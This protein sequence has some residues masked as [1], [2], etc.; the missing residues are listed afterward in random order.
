MEVVARDLADNCDR[1]GSIDRRKVAAVLVI[2]IVIVA[3]DRA[4]I[5]RDDDA[6]GGE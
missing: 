3:Y 4:Q 1:T 2:V 5:D 6:G